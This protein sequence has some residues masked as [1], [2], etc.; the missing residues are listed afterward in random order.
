MTYSTFKHA[1]CVGCIKA[2]KQ[3]WYCVFV[4]RKDIWEKAKKAE[5]EI[6]HSIMAKEYLKELKSEFEKMENSGILPT[7][8]I[9]P[10]AFWAMVRKR[11][12]GQLIFDFDENLK[13]CECVF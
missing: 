2:G 7:E 12:T 5:E 13:P 4:T 8:H 9:E 11:L 3:H 10:A 1:N 6:G